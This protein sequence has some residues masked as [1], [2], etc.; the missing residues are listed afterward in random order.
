M[1][2][3]AN[4][5]ALWTCSLCLTKLDIVCDHRIFRTTD[6]PVIRSC[7]HCQELVF[8]RF[9]VQHLQIWICN[10]VQWFDIG[11]RHTNTKVLLLACAARSQ[12]IQ[13]FPYPSA[14]IEV[15]RFNRNIFPRDVPSSIAGH[16]CYIFAVDWPVLKFDDFKTSIRKIF[17][18][19][20]WQIFPTLKGGE[21]GWLAYSQVTIFLPQLVVDP[22][23]IPL[24]GEDYNQI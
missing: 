6:C 1:L 18:F 8:L 17:P 12:T 10:Y 7:G 19:F 5:I 4:L 24:P 3:A 2:T 21:I 22:P 14:S 20:L 13:V 16:N 11:V 9:M 23:V 15:S